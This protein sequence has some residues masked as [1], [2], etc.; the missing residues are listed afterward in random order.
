MLSLEETL[1][2][3]EDAGIALS[4][5]GWGTRPSL[6]P[7]VLFIVDLDVMP[8]VERMLWRTPRDS[9]R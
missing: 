8:R 5:L 4:Q 6:L 7:R 2:D 1:K 9:G 3:I